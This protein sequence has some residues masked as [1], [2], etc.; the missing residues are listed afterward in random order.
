MTEQPRTVLT[1]KDELEPILRV[2]PDGGETVVMRISKRSVS[3]GSAPDQDIRLPFLGIAPQMARIDMEG[4]GYRLF[5]ITDYP[6]DVLVNGRGIDSELLRDGDTIRL[7]NAS[8]SGVTIQYLNAFERAQKAGS[9]TSG[10]FIFREFPF[11]IGRDPESSI[12]LEN[13]AISWRHAQ[14]TEQ[15]SAH[16]LQDLDSTN[17]TYVNDRKIN[18]SYRLKKDDVI[19]I[20]QVMLVYKGNMLLQLSSVRDFQLDAIGL[21]MTHTRGFL[22]RGAR[23]TMRDVSLSMKTREFIAIIGGSGSGKSTL[24]RALNGANQATAGT[25]LVNGNNLYDDYEVYQP[26]IG[27]VRQADIVHD[28]LT[29]YQ[30]LDYGARLRFPNEPPEARVQR[31]Q[32]VV[33]TVQ[34]DEVRDNQVGSL[35]GGQKKRV[36]IALELMA[37]PR[38]LFMD[39]PSSG[40]DPG[41]DRSMMQTLRRLAYRGHMVVVVT[42]TTLNIELCDKLVLMA[43]GNLCYYGP[44]REAL[45]FFSVRDY[46]EIYNKVLEWRD[47]E[48]GQLLSQDQAAANW[49]E[50]YRQSALYDKHVVQHVEQSTGKA[51][52]KETMLRNKRLRGAQRGTIAQQTGVLTRRSLRLALND[53]RTMIALMIVLPLVGLFLGL[54]SL[55]PIDGGQGKMLVNRFQDQTLLAFFDNLPLNPVN[56]GAD[57]GAEQSNVVA[58]GTFTPASDAQRVLFM[59]ALAVTLLGIFAS[60]YT[61]VEEKALFLRERMTTLRIL[62]YIGSKV[63]VY[64]G[65]ALISCL[66][67]L[68]TL[69]F[70]VQLPAQGAITWGPL[71]IYITLALT[72]LAGVSIGLFLSSLSR[73]LNAVTYLVL[74]LLFVQ[75]LFAGVL[76]QMNGV[77]EAP[78][79]LTVTR[80]SLEALGGS[81]DMQARDAESHFVVEVVPLNPRTGEPLAN[82]P[83]ARQPYRA[84]SALAVTYPTGAGEQLLR[85]AVL[86]GF[87][88]VFL[89]GAGIVLDRSDMY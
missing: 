42:H 11:T 44:P 55:D 69:A 14:I 65:F 25:V 38:M 83:T 20:D 64:G 50:R 87:S 17:G 31:I 7:Q 10:M 43:K 73:Q 18:G 59:L 58:S 13:L 79:R 72:A 45:D 6:G 57:N 12:S 66:L 51:P 29:V 4:T 40:L 53:I 22:G 61:I 35:S 70:G 3:I 78:S 54:I 75:I 77:L 30:T 19:R 63:L 16:V 15:G 89:V 74:A 26:V 34:L 24:L 76:F 28:K 1:S 82:A 2:T 9:G 27:Y 88:V 46:T 60:A 80:W 5:D 41:L 67:A 37:E 36:S 52:A 85:W 81:V 62:P 23:N 71:E 84:P 21:E 39:E 49:A 8:D 56:S 68:V 48:T 33:E 47:K 86:L 32:R